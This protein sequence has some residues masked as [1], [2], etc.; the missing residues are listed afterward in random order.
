MPEYVNYL[1]A[2]L[3]TRT[4]T[5]TIC[6]DHQVSGDRGT[7]RQCNLTS[8]G[9]YLHNLLV[10]LDMCPS[11]PSPVSKELLKIRAINLPIPV[12]FELEIS[13]CV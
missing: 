1:I 8:L 13:F 4:R 7:I 6:T 11:I 10:E 12:V 3:W 9:I 5:F 2:M